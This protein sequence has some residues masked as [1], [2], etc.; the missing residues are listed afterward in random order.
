MVV[1]IM[2]YVIDMWYVWNELMMK[3]WDLECV[4]V[5]KGEEENK[6]FFKKVN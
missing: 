2:V 1:V 6:L 5:K 3:R 4:D